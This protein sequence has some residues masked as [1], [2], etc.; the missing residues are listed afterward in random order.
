MTVSSYPL[1]VPLRGYFCQCVRQALRSYAAPRQL[2][3]QRRLSTTRPR[4]SN[5][6]PSR[7]PT[8]SAR[9]QQAQYKRSVVISAV[10]I[11]AC[12]SAMY[13]VIH[14]DV[15]KLPPKEVSREG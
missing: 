13:G 5:G 11:V 12:A 6:N 10:G 14:L 15:F 7:N 9:E 2:P 4:R 3:A 1:H 8:R